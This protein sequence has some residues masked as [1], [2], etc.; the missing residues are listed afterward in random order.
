MANRRTSYKNTSTFCKLCN[1][2]GHPTDK[3]TH[4]E[5]KCRNCNNWGHNKAA[6]HFEKIICKCKTRS[7]NHPGCGGKRRHPAQG[8][9]T[10]NEETAHIEEVQKES[11]FLT[12]KCD[13][14]IP[15]D[16]KEYNTFKNNVIVTYKNGESL[17]YYDCLAD[18]VTISHVSNCCKAF[19]TFNP[20]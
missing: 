19:K 20:T 8:K 4:L 16:A 14:E 1:I 13:N 7:S 15:I 3:C 12:T 6:C 9:A 11:I 5:K 2:L 18:S 10:K 17:I